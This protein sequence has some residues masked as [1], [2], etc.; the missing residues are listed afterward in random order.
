MNT[1]ARLI[2]ANVLGSTSVA[3]LVFLWAIVINP[4]KWNIAFPGGVVPAFLTM[5]LNVVAAVLAGI[6]GKR[7]WL[8]VTGAAVVTFI[9]LGFF[10][11]LEFIY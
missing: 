1:K 10:Q 8:I 7:P 5:L 9:Y 4:W 2:I 11:K 6:W 3:Y